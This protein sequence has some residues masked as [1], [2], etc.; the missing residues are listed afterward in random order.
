[1]FHYPQAL[2]QSHRHGRCWVCCPL[3][4]GKA[5]IQLTQLAKPHFSHGSTF[6]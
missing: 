4:M 1:M 6:F 3:W 5:E 2:A